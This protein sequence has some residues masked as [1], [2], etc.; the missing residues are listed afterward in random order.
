VLEDVSHW[1]PESAPDQLAPPLLAH[2]AAT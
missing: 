2:L 1:I